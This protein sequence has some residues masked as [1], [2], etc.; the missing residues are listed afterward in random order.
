MNRRKLELYEALF[1]QYGPHTSHTM[2][3]DIAKAFV[4]SERHARTLLKQMSSYLW[5]N[6]LPTKGRGQ[7]QPS[8][9]VIKY[10]N[11]AMPIRP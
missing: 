8:C 3:A 9:P 1:K 10:T 11:Q 5:L 7:K 4:C 6:W 2:M